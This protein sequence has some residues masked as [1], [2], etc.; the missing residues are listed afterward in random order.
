M[1]QTLHI[2]AA[3]AASGKDEPR[4]E[5]QILRLELELHVA[6]PW[7]QRNLVCAGRGSRGIILSQRLVVRFTAFCVEVNL[8]GLGH[9]EWMNSTGGQTYDDA[10]RFM[11]TR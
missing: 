5:T 10:E 9:P 8:C 4:H 6:S 2:V 11:A 3:Q 7:Y 1:A